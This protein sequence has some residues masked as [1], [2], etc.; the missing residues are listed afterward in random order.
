MLV[1]VAT[2]L[3]A[4]GLTACGADTEREGALAASDAFAASVGG[5][6]RA[7]CAL[8]APRAAQALE[9]DGLPCARALVEADLPTTGAH[10]SVT[11]AGH[12]AQVRYA[13]DTVFLALFDDGWR[14]T[15]AG[16]SRASEHRA[17]PYDC[18]VEGG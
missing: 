3:L 14:V 18:L 13:E 2:P 12:S 5:D 8:L 11:V 9:E 6:P 17:E 10:T 15:A 7:A 16:C 1:T 4:L